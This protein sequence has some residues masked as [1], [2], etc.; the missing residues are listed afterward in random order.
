MPSIN[1]GYSEHS[2][3]YDRRWPQSEPPRCS[4]FDLNNLP[5]SRQPSLQH[6]LLCLFRP[7]S[8]SK[9]LLSLHKIRTIPQVDG[10]RRWRVLTLSKECFLVSQQCSIP[11]G[12]PRNF[13]HFF[14]SRFL[15]QDP[16]TAYRLQ[17]EKHDK[18][19]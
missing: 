16:I 14:Q 11:K 7:K 10:G 19:S 5:S 8:P 13:I 3:P 17:R 4:S 1:K 18:L 2:V 12:E 9:P 6:H 15:T